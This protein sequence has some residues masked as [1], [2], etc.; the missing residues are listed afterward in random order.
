MLNLSLEE[1]MK[2]HKQLWETIA[3][4]IKEGRF[5][6][7]RALKIEA[8]NRMGVSPDSF[9]MHHCYLCDYTMD[10]LYEC[11]ECCPCYDSNHLYD[12]CLN[13]L[14]FTFCCEPSIENALKIANLPVVNKNVLEKEK[15]N[16]AI[17]GERTLL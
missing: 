8:L 13:G 3:E 7:P 14:W 17:C 9:P 10:N 5:R 16:E 4:L 11:C 15:D 1:T 2:K 12:S 6:S